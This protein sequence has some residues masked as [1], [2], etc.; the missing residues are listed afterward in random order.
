MIGGFITGINEVGLLFFWSDYLG[1]GE[2]EN[3]SGITERSD[4]RSGENGGGLWEEWRG[5]LG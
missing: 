5:L 1:R 3:Y 2:G 4:H